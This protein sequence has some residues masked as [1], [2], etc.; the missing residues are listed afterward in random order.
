MKFKWERPDGSVVEIGDPDLIVD[1]LNYLGARL[2]TAKADSRLME[3]A[4]LRSKYDDQYGQW[5]WCMAHYYRSQRHSLMM[6]IKKW[7]AVLSWWKECSEGSASEGVSDLQRSL[8]ADLSDDLR[9][10]NWEE[11]RK[12]LDRHPRFKVPTCD[13]ETAICGLI[14]VLKSAASC[15]DGAD[16]LAHSFFDNVIPDQEELNQFDSKKVKFSAEI[17][18]FIAGL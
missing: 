12:I 13:L 14:Q 7:E 16:R 8:L 17:D 2:E 10:K 4:A 5:R 9:P 6:L 18:R 15:H 11:A 3:V 1:V